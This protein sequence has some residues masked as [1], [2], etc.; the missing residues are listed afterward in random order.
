MQDPPKD[1]NKRIALF[2]WREAWRYPKYAWGI[3]FVMPVTLFL[4]QFL[5]PLIAA[6][7]L[8]KLSHQVTRPDQLWQQF[9]AS[10]VWYAVSLLLSIVVLWRVL[11]I[12]NWTLEGLVIRN[13]LRKSFD[14]LMKLDAAFHANHFGGA[15][16]SQTNKLAS[17]YIRLAD[18]LQFQFYGLFIS[19]IFTSV[20]LWRRSAVFVV[21]LWVLSGAFLAAALLVTRNLRQLSAR[22]SSAENTATGQLADAITNVMA[23]KSF[24]SGARESHRFHQATEDTRIATRALMFGTTKKDATF[25]AFT[26]TIGVLSLVLAVIS[27]VRFHA[28]LSTVFLM[29]T[30]TGEVAVKLW[31]ISSRALRDVNRGLGDAREGMITLLT[32]STIQ[33]PKRPEP[34]RIKKGAIAFTNMTFTHDGAGEDHSL[35]RNFSLDVRAGEKI[36]LVGHS[37]SGKTSLTKLLLR[38]MD[39]DAGEITID[40]QN[41]A[42]IKQD[43]LR[44]R[45][46]YVPQEPLLFHRSIRENIAYSNPAASSASIA[47]AAQSAHATEFVSSLP[48]GLDTLVGERGVK[49]SGGQRQRIAIARAMLKDAP[50]LV[51]DEATS[52]LDSESEVLIQDAL[53]KLMQH[54]TALVIAHRLSTVQKMDR[55]VVLDNGRI[56]EQGTHKELL[57]KKGV[58]ANLWAHQSGGFI[59]S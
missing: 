6:H 31:E 43:D 46:A 3:V 7:V 4:H 41:I 45:I 17:S 19:L 8:D 1:L 28:N 47:A 51:L 44:A 21:A 33:D 16:V 58:Y 9:G 18:A 54:R 36:G 55:I 14:N 50:I 38:Y 25:S 15:L 20:L 52:A 24:A 59:E 23:V 30:Y 53:W 49:L 35:F 10:L 57:R 2:Y 42:H 29:L 32:P 48:H 13:V 40:G 12:L 27:V 39:V 22:E 34:V 56:V 37:G 11:I 5:P 26:G